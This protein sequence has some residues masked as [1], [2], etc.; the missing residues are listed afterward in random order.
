[1]R[2]DRISLCFFSHCPYEVID[3]FCPRATLE[4]LDSAFSV[5]FASTN[6][7]VDTTPNPSM[8]DDYISRLENLDVKGGFD[9]VE[10]TKGLCDGNLKIGDKVKTPYIL[11]LEHDWRFLPENINHSLAEILDWFEVDP[12]INYLRFNKR[13]NVPAGWDTNLVPHESLPLVKTPAYSNNPNIISM[14]FYD[15]VS[16]HIDCEGASKGGGVERKVPEHLCEGNYIYG[17]MLH[18]PTV[19]HLPG[20]D[21]YEK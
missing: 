11:F 17:G 3:F 21:N 10:K 8:A 15:R 20:M 9:S 1:M 19:R 7:F 18:E 4:S 16:Q 5:D 6:L 12:Q 2:E 13:R 14:S